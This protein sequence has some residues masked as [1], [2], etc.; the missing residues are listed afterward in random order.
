LGVKDRLLDFDPLRQ[1]VGV[2]LQQGRV[3]VDSD[4]DEYEYV[5]MRR[6]PLAILRS[7]DQALGSNLF[8]PACPKA[9]TQPRAFPDW[10]DK[11]VHD[12]GITLIE[13]FA[14]AADQLSAHADQV[15]AEARLRTRRR[16]AVAAG[17]GILVFTWWCR[18]PV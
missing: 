13:L 18:R 8:A 15:A 11:R 9:R 6:F 2:I 1:F 12:P 7:L 3:Q 16:T 17:V 5:R 10:P 4:S 14:Y